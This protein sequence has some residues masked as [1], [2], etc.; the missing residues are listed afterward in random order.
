VRTLPTTFRSDGFDFQILERE[1]DA[2]LLAK[3][4]HTWNFRIYEV[5]RIQ[6]WPEEWIKGHFTPER[7]AMPRS[8]QWGVHG[9]SFSD[10]RD[11]RRKFYELVSVGQ[12]KAA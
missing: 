6:V 2:A 8:E 11:A 1:A 9:W 3:K 4:K 10:I 7:E 5:V 12:R